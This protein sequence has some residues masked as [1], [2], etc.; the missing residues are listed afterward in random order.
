MMIKEA[1]DVD[2]QGP[3]AAKAARADDLGGDF[4]KEAFHQVEPGGR[5]G[6]EMD[7]ETG[8]TLKPGG[9]FGVLVGRVVVADDVK[10]ELG[11]DLLIAPKS[12]SP[13]PDD[14]R[15]EN[16]LNKISAG[17]WQNRRPDG[18]GGFCFAA[19]S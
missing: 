6:N 8:M 14:A 12:P 9:N 4:A 2:D 3:D 7:V 10:L 11:N 17:G 5:G 16:S 1:E 19:S 13:V 18:F 15:R